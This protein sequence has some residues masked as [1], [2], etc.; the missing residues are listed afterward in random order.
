M[1]VTFLR[2]LIA[3]VALAF[4]ARHAVAA[5]W[6]LLVPSWPYILA[7]AILGFTA[8]NALFYTAAYQTNAVNIAI[9][10]G[11]TPIL[12][13]LAQPGGPAPGAI[14]I[15]RPQSRSTFVRRCPGR[16][17]RAIIS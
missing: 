1:V 13:C 3:C 14:R 2:W 12:C 15:A 6:R 11:S 5:E 8:F 7:M 9:I 10:Q 4:V 16:A 17:Q